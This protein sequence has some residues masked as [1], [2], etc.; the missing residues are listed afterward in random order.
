MN[1]YFPLP[2][3]WMAA[4]LAAILIF[5]SFGGLALA[6]TPLPGTV[7][8]NANVRSGPGTTYA[9]VG[10]ASQD[11][12]VSIIATNA[13]GDW[14]Q[15][16]ED[17]WIAAFLV[18]VVN[19]APVMS[20]SPTPVTAQVAAPSIASTPVATNS[21]GTANRN[22]N[23]RGGPAT[24]YAVVGSVR[25]GQTLTLIGRNADSSWYQIEGSAWIAAFLVNGVASNPPELS[26][27]TPAPAAPA[28]TAAPPPAVS[29]GNEFVLVEQRLWDPYENGGSLDGPS[30]HCGYGRRLVVNVLDANGNRLNG[31]GVQVQ[32]GAREIEVT[33]AQGRGDGVAEFVLG[34]GQDVKVIRNPD[35]RAATSDLATGLSTNPAGIAYDALISGRYCQDEA[36]CRHFAETNSCNGHFSW[37]VTFQRTGN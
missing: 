2:K 3:P 8:R 1:V 32:Y 37:T 25:T 10:T 33:G 14:Y 26:T 6:Q 12:A 11:Q 21:T 22:A 34:G 36:T 28:P 27:A 7:N 19:A 13:A 31:V 24:T 16:G 17:R 35:G 20:G 9:V 29:N 15:L 4:L 5:F 23:L 18:N 30:V